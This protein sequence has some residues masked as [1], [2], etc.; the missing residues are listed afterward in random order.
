MGYRA[1]KFLRPCC[2][3]VPRFGFYFYVFLCIL[4][5]LSEASVIGSFGLMGLVP[6]SVDFGLDD[7]T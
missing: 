3:S 6:V 7:G 5:P 2:S 1:S 4:N